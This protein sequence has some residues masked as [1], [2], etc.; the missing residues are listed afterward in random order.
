MTSLPQARPRP[1][2]PRAHLA[3]PAPAVIRFQDGRRLSA[4]LKT[5]SVTG[6]LLAMRVPVDAGSQ[7]KLMML[8]AAGMV[9]ASAEMLS[10]LT[11]GLQ[12]FRFVE[13]DH[14]G[15]T[16]VRAVVESYGERVR[17]EQRQIETSRAW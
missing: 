9:L 17:G 7:G 6:G 11:W 8:T 15:Q 5:V 2:A 13:L 4:K 3:D 16:R 14:D 10:P 12:A 1:R